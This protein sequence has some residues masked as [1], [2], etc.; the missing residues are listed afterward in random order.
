MRQGPTKR[1]EQVR[2]RRGR[3]DVGGCAQACMRS[4]AACDNWTT[5]HIVNCAKR[6]TMC[7][8]GTLGQKHVQAVA[9]GML[10]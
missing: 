7:R 9:A 3:Q 10:Q 2:I 1:Q 8:A 6:Q 5:Q 4:I